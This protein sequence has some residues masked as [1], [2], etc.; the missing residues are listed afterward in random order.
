[1]NL[2]SSEL[3]SSVFQWSHRRFLEKRSRNWILIGRTL[4]FTA[5]FITGMKTR[6]VYTSALWSHRTAQCCIS[7]LHSLRHG[8][9]HA[10][11]TCSSP[12]TGDILTEFLKLG[13]TRESTEE[14]L[15]R[16]L[17]EEEGKGQQ[18]SSLGC[19]WMSATR[20]H[21]SCHF[22]ASLGTW[23]LKIVQSWS[24][25]LWGRSMKSASCEDQLCFVAL[26]KTLISPPPCPSWRSQQQRCPFPNYLFPTWFT[27]R[28]STSDA[29]GEMSRHWIQ[30]CSIPSCWW[31]SLVGT[32]L[33]YGATGTFAG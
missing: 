28:G 33:L 14:I 27:V 20:V 10:F 19:F 32:A 1:M 15:G 16:G 24:Q 30:T 29:I 18:S 26:Q 25:L 12:H 22:V 7:L 9:V 13:S 31:A 4:W 21:W 3:R 5:A 6:T 17:M 8:R 23:V 11:V 2:D